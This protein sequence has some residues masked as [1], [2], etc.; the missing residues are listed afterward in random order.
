MLRNARAAQSRWSPKRSKRRSSLSAA[1]R[2]AAFARGERRVARGSS[3]S[4]ADTLNWCYGVVVADH[5][6]IIAERSSGGAVRGDG[7]PGARSSAGR[8]IS[9]KRL[10]HCPRARARRRGPQRS[11]RRSRPR[12]GQAGRSRGVPC[13]GGEGAA[14]LARIDEIETH[15]FDGALPTLFRIAESLPGA[16]RIRR[17][18]RM[19]PSARPAPKRS[20]IS[21]SVA[22]ATPSPTVRIADRVSPS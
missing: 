17:W 5:G 20:S 16:T 2:A 13:P 6:L 7:D 14:A 18:R 1:G 22:S 15:A 10:A 11:R 12:W 3:A 9:P 8:R 19:L 21:M 4:S